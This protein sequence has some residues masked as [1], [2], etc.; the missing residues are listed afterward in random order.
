MPSAPNYP[1][2]SWTSP[3]NP[4]E[5]IHSVS[6]DITT[7]QATGGGW[8]NS[9]VD[10]GALIGGSYEVADAERM[11]GEQMARARGDYTTDIRRAFVDLGMPDTSQLSG[12]LSKYIDKD[13]IQKAVANK[14]STYGDIANQVARSTKT[15]N[16]LL[17][18]RGGLASGLTTN[19]ATE[20]TSAAEKARY[21][22][23]RD[24]LQQ[25][26]TGLRRISDLQAQLAAGVAQAR[27][28]AAARLA[29][30]YAFAPSQ[31]QPVAPPGGQPDQPNPPGWGDPSGLAGPQVHET[32]PNVTYSA[33][34]G[35]NGAPWLNWGMYWGGKGA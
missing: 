7:P 14:Y 1:S 32:Y 19:M 10:M 4:A 15:N 28:A 5:P 22:G 34:E 26:T 9:N 8:G 11:M 6:T 24:F 31:P 2:T 20:L 18:A 21:Q 23:L 33:P 17:A 12:D 29:Q 3:E 16:A 27:A 13:T 35:Y 25:G 30:M